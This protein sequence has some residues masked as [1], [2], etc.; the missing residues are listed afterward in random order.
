MLGQH[1]RMNC[2]QVA[3]HHIY[4]RFHIDFAPNSDGQTSRILRTSFD[5]IL[6]DP[7]LVFIVM[8]VFYQGYRKHT[9]ELDAILI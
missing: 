9:S 2:A 5:I 3:I 1:G 8:K 4:T 6:E 7:V